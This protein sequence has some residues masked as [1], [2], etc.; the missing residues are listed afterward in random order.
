MKWN[1]IYMY[2]DWIEFNCV[3]YAILLS[4]CSTL[5]RAHYSNISI[6]SLNF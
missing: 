2:V 5:A 4:V 6:E 1:I 3:I